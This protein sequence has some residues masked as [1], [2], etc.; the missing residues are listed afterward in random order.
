M[1]YRPINSASMA[2]ESHFR[3]GDMEE[4][5]FLTYDEE[6]KKKLGYHVTTQ[7][8]RSNED[9]SSE[10]STPSHEF[11][12]K[13]LV[14][15]IPVPSSS[16]KR[17]LAKGMTFLGRGCGRRLKSKGGRTVAK[18]SSRV[19]NAFEISSSAPITKVFFVIECEVTQ[20]LGTKGL[21]RRL[22]LMAVPPTLR[23]A[24]QAPQLTESDIEPFH[25]QPIVLMLASSTQFC[26]FRL[27]QK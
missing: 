23:A 13:D 10:S 4:L 8:V 16:V 14:I 19:A 26:H 24:P 17:A 7:S 6:G 2:L 1:W 25:Q 20:W 15:R 22:V 18:D 12:E 3:L 9:S 27:E 5:T 11:E 21:C